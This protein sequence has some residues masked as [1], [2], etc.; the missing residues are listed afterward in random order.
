MKIILFWCIYFDFRKSKDE[1]F[2][3]GTPIFKEKGSFFSLESVKG[4]GFGR[5]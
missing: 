2:I 3:K 4:G 5:K 1:I